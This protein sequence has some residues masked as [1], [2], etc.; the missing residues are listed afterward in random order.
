VSYKHYL[1]CALIA[2]WAAY[3]LQL[4]SPL[5]LNTDATSFLTLAESWLDGQGFVIDG[6]PT[7]FP[8]GYPLLLVA[9]ARSGLA[10]SASIIGLNLVMLASG[11]AGTA[12]LLR[13]SFRFDPAVIALLCMMTLLSWVFVKHATLPLSD[14]PYFGLSMVCLATLRWSI[15]QSS[16][17]RLIGLSVATILM[18]AAISVRT[19]GIALVPALAVSC[20]PSDA[21]TK[22]PLWL[23]RDPR[24]SV[25]FFATLFVATVAASI[26]VAQTRYFSEMLAEWVGFSELSRMRL[27]D[28]GELV[29]NTSMAKLPRSLQTV[30]PCAGAIGAILVCCGAAR[31]AKFGIVDVYTVCYTAILL[32]WPYRDCRFWLPVFPMLAAYAWIAFEAV[33]SVQWVRKA[34]LAYV[35][36]FALMGCVGLS[37]SSRI[38]LSG[39]RFPDLYG[40]GVYRDS[41]RALSASRSGRNGANNQG[42]PTLVRLLERYGA[43][44]RV[45]RYPG[46][47]PGEVQ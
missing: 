25:V 13:R 31:R 42:D 9:L 45:A 18:T 29:I 3:F 20:L 22:L 33:A 35:A 44:I 27:E 36:V 24:R 11:C 43:G 40:G 41:Y 7:H 15:D 39:E 5:R 26:A 10:C 14:V 2:L 46:A 23:K 28:W 4:A 38:S 6:Q 19:V 32:I 16:S 34:G 1:A 30:F 47:D 12:Y 8:V 17:R 37:Y 21:W